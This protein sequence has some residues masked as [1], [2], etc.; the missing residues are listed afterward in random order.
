MRQ[1]VTQASVHRLLAFI[2]AVLLAACEPGGAGGPRSEVPMLWH[3]GAEQPM[4]E[5]QWALVNYWAVWCKPCVKEIPELNALAAA[6]PTL[7]VVGINY[8]QPAK[9][10]LIR[11]S[12][13]LGIEFALLVSHP[14]SLALPRPTVLPTSYILNAK[15]E[16][17]AT[18]T[19]P[20]TK[21]SLQAAL[22]KLGF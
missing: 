3:A 7:Q 4:A 8:D 22:V 20:Q 21:A 17:V 2:A 19:G 11:Q 14:G 1:G 5:A 15:G 12:E 9:A 13:K 10:E 18:L 6:E 16:R